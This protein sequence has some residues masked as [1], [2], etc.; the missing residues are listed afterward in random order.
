M[1]KRR[2]ERGMQGAAISTVTGR[3]LHQGFPLGSL[4]SKFSQLPSAL[5]K[6]AHLFIEQMLTEMPRSYKTSTHDRSQRAYAT[7]L[8]LCHSPG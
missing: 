7:A 4:Y 2:V 1:L 3:A 8:I 5:L 6:V